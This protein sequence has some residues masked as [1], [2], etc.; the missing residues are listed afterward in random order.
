M[1]ITKMERTKSL[2]Q[3]PTYGNL[4]TI[5]SIDGGGI[6]GIIPS[7]VIGF[8]ETEL[9]RLDGEDARLADY[10]DV[11]AGTSTGGLMTMMLAAPDENNR[12]LYAAK[13]IKQF[14]LDEGP[15]IFQQRSYAMSMLRVMEGPKH[16]GEHLRNIVIEKLGDKKLDETLTNIVIPTFDIKR[17]R[18][19]I[20]SSYEAKRTPS[21]NAKL[22][23]ICIGT[24]AA[25]TYLPAHY[26]QT[27][28]GHAGE[29]REFHLIDGGLAAN[30]PSLVAMNEVC[31]EI[32]CGSSDFFPIKPTD[33]HRFL[34]LSL[35]TGS[36]KED[37]KYSAE[38]AASWGL[39]G[40]LTS[41]GST[42]LVEAFMRGSSDMVDFHLNTVF[43]AL[44]TEEN[45][46]RIQCDSLT[47]EL[48]TVDDSSDET[49]EKL[50]RVGEE[51]LKEQVT[52]VNLATGIYEPRSRHTN[53]EILTRLAEVLSNERRLRDIKSP[54]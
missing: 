20:F 16:D 6:R 9:Q 7:I 33:Y 3:P 52:Q 25:P 19:T 36:H 54:H 23:D 30:N 47:E 48:V 15:K 37:G 26:F 10:F 43:K 32:S 41:G 44:H 14:Y 35:G 34:V 13:D 40:W 21:L 4:I 2:L 53:E 51:L 46:I 11:M 5:L 24:S 18:P 39:L 50:V 29:I 12:P 42:P 31:N 22:S 8:L 1:S 28:A 49:L 38:Q 27:E 45:Y 17:M